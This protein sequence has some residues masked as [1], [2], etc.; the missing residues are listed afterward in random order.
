M[1]HKKHSLP[2]A[3]VC[4]KTARLS[5]I[6]PINQSGDFHFSD[7]LLY[8]IAYEIH[9]GN[10]QETRSTSCFYGTKGCKV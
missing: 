2:E 9:K 5:D 4:L 8:I 6:L 10:R 1:K 3:F 7:N